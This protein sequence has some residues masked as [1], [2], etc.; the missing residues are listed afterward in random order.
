MADSNITLLDDMAK[1]IITMLKRD[2]AIAALDN[3]Y[4]QEKL[5]P[6]DREKNELNEKCLSVQLGKEIPDSIEHLG[7]IGGS[8]RSYKIDCKITV[9]IPQDLRTATTPTLNEF[10][11][12]IKKVW[13]DA[14]KG[15][16]PYPDNIFDYDYISSEPLTVVKS[17][18][19]IVKV[20][21][22]ILPYEGTVYY[23]QS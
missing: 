3:W 19:N 2:T 23:V 14:D 18:R 6:I 17:L 9:W 1:N 12:R 7:H 15:V 4:P 22:D 11:Q 5:V 20:I 16:I 10:R 8:Q 13:N 21:S